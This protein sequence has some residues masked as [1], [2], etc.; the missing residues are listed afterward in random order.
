MRAKFGHFRRE[1]ICVDRDHSKNGN[2]LSSVSGPE[3]PDRVNV[4]SFSRNVATV[5][6]DV[7]NFDITTRARVNIT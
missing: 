4:R 3:R 5:Y 1:M 2:A 6:S 7:F